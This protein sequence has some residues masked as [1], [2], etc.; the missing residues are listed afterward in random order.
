MATIVIDQEKCQLCAAC[1]NACPFG[2]LQINNNKLEINSACTLCKQ[3]LNSCPFA[4]V[5]Y[6]EA[7]EIA[8]DL[9]SWRDILV[10]SETA[11]SHV[12][13]VTIELI[14]KALELAGQCH[15]RVHCVVVGEQ[16]QVCAQSLLGYGLSNILVFQ[17]DAFRYYRSDYFSQALA[18]AIEHLKPAIV[19]VGATPL[20]RSLAPILATRF[21]SGLT[22]DCT[23]LQVKEDGSL[24]QIRPAFGGD[25]M[26]QIFTP[27]HRP[28]FATVRYKTMDKAPF[29]ADN[30][31]TI[32]QMSP[33]E[34]ASKITVL[35]ETL[36]EITENISEAE[37]IV[38]IGSGLKNS[39]DIPI[40][41]ALANQLNGQLACSRP[42]VEKGW[43]PYTKQIGLSGRTVKPKLIITVG[44]SGAVQFTAAMKDAEFIIAINSD[45]NAPIFNIAHLGIVGDLYE[46]VP[47]LV[48][49]LKGDSSL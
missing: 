32:I 8:F 16:A 1:L 6:Q 12:H 11:G 22:A 37:I 27:S 3:C 48:K 23:D 28:Q 13:P 15:Y 36:K 7:D 38:A 49:R 40:V 26:A 20:G 4:A 2:A 41:Q 45:E 21:H 24:V 10:F 30:S 35:S 18:S 9:N 33:P 25:I 19:L 5:S 31:G 42:L 46:I 44:V 43:F 14:G 47:Q 29:I 17:S 39:D 34:Q